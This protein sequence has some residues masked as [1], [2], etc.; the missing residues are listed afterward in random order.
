MNRLSMRACFA[1]VAMTAALV[2]SAA[3]EEA[4][5]PPYSNTFDNAASLDGFTIIDGNND[6]VKWGIE[7]GAAAITY[8]EKLDMNDWLIT[9]PLYLESGTDYELTLN[10][11]TNGHYERVE[12]CF[13][14]APVADA[15]TNVLISPVQLTPKNMGK[16]KAMNLAGTI[17][18]SQ[19][20][21]YYVGIHGISEPDEYTLFVDDLQ[22]VASKPSVEGVT[23][24]YSNSFDNAA[25]LDGYTILDSNGDEVAWKWEAGAVA[26]TYNE[27]ENMNDWL[28]TMPLLLEGG[29]SYEVSLQAWTN[30]HYERLEV[31]FGDAPTAEAMKNVVIEPVQLTPHNYGQEKA[32]TLTGVMRPAQSGAYYLGIHGISDPDM[33]TLFIDNLQIAAARSGLIPGTV[34]DLQAVAKGGASTEVTVSFKA[35]A[36]SASGETLTSDI[37]KIE[38]FRNDVESP[39]KIFENVAPGTELSFTDTPATA[40]EY[41]YTVVAYNESGA[42]DEVSVKVYCGIGV[43]QKVTGVT[44]SETADGGV[45]IGWDA[46]TK[47]I[48]DQTLDPA[49]VTYNIYTIDDWGDY[50]PVK[51]GVT[52]TSCILEDVAPA[53]GQEFVRY[54]VGAAD[55]A[56]VGTIVPTVF[57]PVGAPYAGMDESFAG[58][59]YGNYVWHQE[60]SLMAYWTTL[61]DETGYLA[62]DGDNGYIAFSA[63]QEGDTGTLISAKISLAGFLE[64]TLTFYTYNFNSNG[65]DMNTLAVSARKIGG[66]YTQ[67]LSGTVNA[68]TGS[69][70]SWGKVTVDLSAFDGDV[71]QLMFKAAAVN[72]GSLLLDNIIVNSSKQSGIEQI[73][74]DAMVGAAG[75]NIIVSGAADA[76][77]SVAAVSGAVIYAGRGDV[78][79]PVSKGVYVVKVGAKAVKL[80]VK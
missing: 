37:T 35:P 7:D 5:T 72:Y 66:D 73:N 30:G 51:T 19:S 75:G 76:E 58:G 47:D 53:V 70:E 26:V 60:A 20:G 64:P 11:W 29:S 34:T 1:A 2:A 9:V 18:P 14:D 49:S 46:V 56:G 3:G 54:A 33:Y 8:N 42:G 24:P 28:I 62:V 4:V 69:K 6:G 36:L 80:L 27:K 22:I 59:K 23:P 78:T 16:E 44:I 21:V 39:V 68:L 43:P 45:L 52:G 41:T 40:G 12:I 57:I 17:Q 25:S 79:I 77:V 31:S 63:G 38:V 55:E 65:D 67:L 61:T 15:M 48:L 50:I 10:A 13:G 71:I 74:T 32:L